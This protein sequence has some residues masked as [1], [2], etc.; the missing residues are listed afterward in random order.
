MLLPRRGLHG[1]LLDVPAP[2]HGQWGQ[3]LAL[4]ESSLCVGMLAW[5]GLSSHPQQCQ[6]MR[7]CPWHCS[8]PMASMGACG[9][10]FPSGPASQATQ[11]T[12]RQHWTPWVTPQLLLWCSKGGTLPL[13]LP[14]FLSGDRDT[15]VRSCLFYFHMGRGDFKAEHPWDCPFL[16]LQCC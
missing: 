14:G 9:V 2:H 7:G 13:S 16:T 3:L 1:R 6:P 12:H 15:Q 10:S 11:G 8:V 4:L 5:H